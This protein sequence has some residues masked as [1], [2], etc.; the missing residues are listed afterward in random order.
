MPREVRSALWASK[1]VCSREVR[2][3]EPVAVPVM[4]GVG[5]GDGGVFGV[6][7]GEGGG[8]CVG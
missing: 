1:I 4:V 6:K 3:E 2:V 7:V 8:V 5:V